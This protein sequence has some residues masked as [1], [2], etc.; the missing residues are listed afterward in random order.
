MNRH[1]HSGLSLPSHKHLARNVAI[2]SAPV[3]DELVL[4]LD[5]HGASQLQPCVAIGESVLMG[6]V[7][8]RAIGMGANLHSPVS[9]Q[10]RAIEDRAT[11][12]SGAGTGA[13]QSPAIVISNDHLDQRDSSQH[14]IPDWLSLSPVQLCEQ[15]ASGGIVGL[16]GAAFPTA[17]KLNAHRHHAIDCLLINGIECEPFI[18]CDDRLMR[19]RAVPILNGVQILMHA[20]QAARCLIGIEADKPE[21]LLAMRTALQAM[22]DSRIEIH[23]IAPAYPSGDEG[24]L[25]TKLLGREIPRHG[26]PVNIGVIVQNVATAYACAQWVLSGVP[27]ISRIVTVSGPGIAQPANLEVRIGTAMHELVAACAARDVDTN[28]LIM[29]GAMMGRAL[30]SDRMPVVKATNCLIVAAHVALKS[31]TGELPCIR[32][33]ECAEACPVNLLPQLLLLHARNDNQIALQELGLP[34]CIECGCCDYVC[35]S[36]IPL[37]SRFHAAKHSRRSA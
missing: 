16:G 21:A 25:I 1:A 30:Q 35:P 31:S 33:G 11:P 20:A 2:T 36:N 8:A 29:G 18:C 6:Q 37:A 9:G 26:L 5:Q 12:K 4:L 19:E 10:V 14:A 27:L 17:T 3:P 22:A 13:E 24:Q 23:A 15:L 28:M 7:I 32:C 34:D